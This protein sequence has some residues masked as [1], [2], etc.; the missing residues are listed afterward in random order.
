MVTETNPTTPPT[1]HNP[2]KL[3]AQ[4]AKAAKLIAAID[5]FF[6]S[7]RI[8]EPEIQLDTLQRTGDAGWAE[9]AS[10]AHVPVPS[11]TTRDLVLDEYRARVKRSV[12]MQIA[13]L[14]A[15]ALKASSDEPRPYV[16]PPPSYPNLRA[17]LKEKLTEIDR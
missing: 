3:E 1:Q 14:V 5:D 12:D 13:K 17:A 4:R 11:E 10:R 15:S 2:F 8:S 16:P 9:A 7:V 6:L